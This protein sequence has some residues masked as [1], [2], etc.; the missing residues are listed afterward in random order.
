M[1]IDIKV[2]IYARFTLPC[3][4]FPYQCNVAPVWVP[5]MPVAK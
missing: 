4:F 3:S 5:M 2:K 1:H